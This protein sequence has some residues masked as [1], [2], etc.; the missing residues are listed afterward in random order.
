MPFSRHTDTVTR[1]FHI[2]KKNLNYFFNIF[3]R[4]VTK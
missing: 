3:Y 1:Y 4:I 2:C